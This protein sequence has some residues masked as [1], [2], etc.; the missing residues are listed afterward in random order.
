MKYRHFMSLD[1]YSQEDLDLYKAISAEQVGFCALGD[2]MIDIVYLIE[3]LVNSLASW[4]DG[5][6][7]WKWLIDQKFY[8]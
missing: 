7:D 2:F 3:R 1:V 8:E 5:L 6:I 4:L